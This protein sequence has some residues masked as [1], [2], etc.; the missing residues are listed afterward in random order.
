ME[1]PGD[2]IYVRIGDGMQIYG[3]VD[4][5]RGRIGHW[6]IVSGDRRSRFRVRNYPTVHLIAA[7]SRGV[8]QQKVQMPIRFAEWRLTKDEKYGLAS[9]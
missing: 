8:P 9:T 2:A 6:P 3:L 7:S 4:R 1:K 5:Y